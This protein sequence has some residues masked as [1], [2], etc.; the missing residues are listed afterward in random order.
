MIDF[1]LPIL[2]ASVCGYLLGSLNSALLVSLFMKH[3]D[4]RTHGSGNAGMT[5]MLRTYGK[6]AALITAVGDL[7]KAV[8]AVFLGR[9]IFEASGAHPGFDPGYIAGLFVLVGHIFPVFFRFRGGKGVMPALGIILLV[10]PYAFLVMFIIALPVFL[11]SRTISIV[12]VIS[13]A[14]LPFVTL[15]I[16]LLRHQRALFDTSITLIYAILVIFS[17]RENIRRLLHGSEKPFIS[18]KRL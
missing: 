3:D 16:C 7:L 8:A 10:N 15:S 5:N 14:A 17:H 18:K 13:A 4:I 12:S 11:I 9:F 2:I 1:L 6:K